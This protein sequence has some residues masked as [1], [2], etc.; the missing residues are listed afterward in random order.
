M[1]KASQRRAAECHAE[2]EVR[3]LRDVGNVQ[4][5]CCG[6]N[7]HPVLNGQNAP[8]ELKQICDKLPD[9]GVAARFRNNRAQQA[10]TLITE[11]AGSN[12]GHEA[13]KLF[14][15]GV[16]GDGR[17]VYGSEQALEDQRFEQDLFGVEKLVESFFGHSRAGRDAVHRR[18]VIAM[19]DQDRTG[20]VENPVASFRF[21]ELRWAATAGLFPGFGLASRLTGQDELRYYFTDRIDVC[22]RN[23]LVSVLAG[24]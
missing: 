20:G 24:N 12:T 10:Q 6:L 13:Q 18:G 19:G 16:R 22:Q 4:S 8:R 7:G 17:V 21:V 5:A 14:F 1:C 23:P 9:G 15:H 11:H 3:G 2:K